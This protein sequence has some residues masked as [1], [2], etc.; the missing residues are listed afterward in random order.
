M[1]C[2]VFINFMYLMTI[3]SPVHF[4]S[5]ISNDVKV[6]M[7]FV[8]SHSPLRHWNP[9]LVSSGISL[10]SWGEGASLALVGHPSSDGITIKIP[11]G[12]DVLLHR[13]ASPLIFSYWLVKTKYDFIVRSVETGLWR[14]LLVVAVISVNAQYLLP[15][16]YQV[17]QFE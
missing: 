8:R 7:T 11:Y 6:E 15:W 1:K 14:W 10:T 4:A 16:T 13:P 9:G 12:V 2:L 3:L 5:L 17:L